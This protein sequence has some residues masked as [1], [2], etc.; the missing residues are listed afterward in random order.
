MVLGLTQRL[1]EMSTGNI[2]GGGGGKGRPA[3]R[4]EKVTA[5]C[6]PIV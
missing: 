3:R 4:A 6:D 2:A 5:I 1:T